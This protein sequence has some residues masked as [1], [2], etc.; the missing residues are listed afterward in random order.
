M[1]ES[2]LSRIKVTSADFSAKRDKK[3]AENQRN[4]LDTITSS[5]KK[6]SEGASIILIKY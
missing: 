4:A 3:R 6:N 1:I 2:G 5:V